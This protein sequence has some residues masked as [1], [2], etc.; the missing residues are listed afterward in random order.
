[1]STEP[2]NNSPAKS[3]IEPTA[4]TTGEASPRQAAQ[5][6]PTTGNTAAPAMATT[7]SNSKS[8]K[9]NEKGRKA[10]T[11]IGSDLDRLLTDHMVKYKL[12]ESE[13]LR[14]LIEAGL[15]Q[16]HIALIPRAHPKEF[17]L[18][19]GKINDLRRDLHSV[20]S[21][22]NAPLPTARDEQLCKQVLQWRETADRLLKELPKLMEEARG[23]LN[24]LTG[25]TAEKRESIRELNLYLQDWIDQ[26]PRLRE[27]ALKRGDTGS[28]KTHEEHLH[29]FNVL[30]SFIDGFGL[31]K[32]N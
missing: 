21:R 27:Q 32:E 11:T 26:S 2:A 14:Q 22:L 24:E 8:K 3:S 23:H 9:T 5:I 28:V 6:D 13:A 10:S 30:K 16:K 20:R 19:I 29:R 17:E 25:L 7:S 4:G 1:M 12:T 31:S 18:F 15:G